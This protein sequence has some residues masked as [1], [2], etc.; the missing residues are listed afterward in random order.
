MCHGRREPRRPF[1][2]SFFLLGLALGFGAGCATSGP[3]AVKVAKTEELWS[4]EGLTGRRITTEHFEVISTLR[5][6]AFEEALPEFLEAVYQRYQKMLPPPEDEHSRLTVYVFGIRQEWD[7][8]TQRRFP[9]RYHVYSRIRH[10][11]YTEGNTSV[12][13]Y[14]S[15]SATLA[16]LTHEAWHQYLGSR[17][18]A[19]IPA[20]LNEG[21]ACYHEALHCV[22]DKPVFTPQR[23][24]FRI[25][26]LCEAVQDDT[27]LS[28]Q[29]IVDTDAG[30]VISQDNRRITQVYYAQAWALVTFLRHGGGG[31]YAEAFDQ[32]LKDIA[33]GTFRIRVGAAR[34]GSSDP[35]GV[36]VGRAAFEAYFGCAPDALADEYY[37]HLVRVCGF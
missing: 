8:F 25:N 30:Q 14:V 5:D 37:D 7:R 24:T 33:D 32:L 20:W 28:L 18:D 10:G 31:R 6:A 15:R 22:G 29:Q 1:Y 9:T 12:S 2:L 34:L 19:P 23:N 17:F 36:S 35:S 27:L 3:P 4:Y 13:F 26:S 16:T 21:L 11:G